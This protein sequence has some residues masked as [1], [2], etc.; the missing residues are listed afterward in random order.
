MVSYITY[1]ES[2]PIHDIPIDGDK[3]TEVGMMSSV[4]YLMERSVSFRRFQNIVAI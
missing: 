3:K 1:R 4:V 2:E